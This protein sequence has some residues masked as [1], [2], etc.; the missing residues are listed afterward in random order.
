MSFACV[1]AKTTSSVA[2]KPAG[3]AVEANQK[4]HDEEENNKRAQHDPTIE[5]V[6]VTSFNGAVHVAKKDMVDGF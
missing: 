3:I 6:I 2:E 1:V 4:E 5:S